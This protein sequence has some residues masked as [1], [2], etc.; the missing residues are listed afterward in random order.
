MPFQGV[1]M[2]AY[3][4]NSVYSKNELDPRILPGVTTKPIVIHLSIFHLH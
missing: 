1:R 3:V 2:Y 4:T